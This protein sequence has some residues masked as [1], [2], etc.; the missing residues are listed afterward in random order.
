MAEMTIGVLALQGDF[1][2]HKEML[3]W[4]G[5]RA[6]EVRKPEELQ[7]CEGLIIPGGESTT[8]L[9]QIDFIHLREALIQ[10][11]RTKP[12]FGTCAGLIILAQ[13]VYPEKLA[14]LALIDIVVERNAYGRQAD[15]F[16]TEIEVCL[17]NVHLKKYPAVFIRAPRIRH[18]GKE[19]DILAKYEGEPVLIRQG[20]FLGATFHPELSDD[21]AI[22][23]F[24]LDLVRKNRRK[25]ASAQKEQQK[26]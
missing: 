25:L 20:S 26:S 21:S 2:K 23:S 13:E 15:S 14:S 9:R 10:F 3:E 24:F 8:I 16:S 1:Q 17:E 6:I 22:H 5:C 11:G 19:V 4:L 12:M 18:C 7:A